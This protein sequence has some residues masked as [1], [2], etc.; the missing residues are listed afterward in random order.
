MAK[1]FQVVGQGVPV[2]MSDANAFQIVD[3]DKDG[4]YCSKKL[5]KEH[6]DG[7]Y[8]VSEGDNGLRKLVGST[9]SKTGT[10]QRHDQHKR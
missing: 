9:I 6:R 2:R 1:C 5:W 8:C 10:L 3:R 7:D 4:Q